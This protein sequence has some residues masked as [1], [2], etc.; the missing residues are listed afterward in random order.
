[1]EF[2]GEVENTKLDKERLKQILSIR[3][4]PELC[5]SISTVIIDEMSHGVIYC[6]WG[7]FVIH[8]EELDNGIRFSLPKCCN[9]LTW[10]ITKQEDS[11]NTVIHCT[12]NKSDH[13]EYFIETL[14]DFVYDWTNGLKNALLEPEPA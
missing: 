14:R 3:R 9:A 13:D 6:V 10:T 1:M 12:I 2:F 11:D 5:E 4:L 7:E 8:R